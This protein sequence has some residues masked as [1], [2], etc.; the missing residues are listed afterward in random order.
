MTTDA[1]PQRGQYYISSAAVQRISFSRRRR[2]ESISFSSVLSV[3]LKSPRNQRQRKLS[4]TRASHR[5]NLNQYPGQ[6]DQTM[7]PD[8]FQFK[9]VVHNPQP[10]STTATRSQFSKTQSQHSF[11]KSVPFHLISSLNQTLLLLYSSSILTNHLRVGQVQVLHD[12]DKRIN[13]LRQPRI[14]LLLLG[15]RRLQLAPAKKIS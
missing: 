15:H 6:P 8:S 14:E 12:V 7:E 11:I 2:P 4:S 10:S 1:I 9:V 3:E 13:V 5:D